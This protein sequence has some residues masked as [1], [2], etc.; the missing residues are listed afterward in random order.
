MHCSHFCSALLLMMGQT[1]LCVCSLSPQLGSHI[2]ENMMLQLLV[3]IVEVGKE[4]A[5]MNFHRLPHQ[6]KMMTQ[7]HRK[8]EYNYIFNYRI[9]LCYF[10][11]CLFMLAFSLVNTFVYCTSYRIGSR[12]HNCMDHSIASFNS[13]TLSSLMSTVTELRWNLS[14]L[15]RILP[16][17][18]V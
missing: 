15:C 1:I 12:I 14:E 18:S 7:R 5:L 11:I 13:A 2:M 4:S 16:C 17:Q 10:L 9:C 3:K 6:T 8:C